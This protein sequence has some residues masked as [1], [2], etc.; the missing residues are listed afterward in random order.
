MDEVLQGKVACVD[1]DGMY[2]TIGY[3]IGNTPPFG[4]AHPLR[5][6]A[7]QALPAHETV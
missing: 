3:M 6:A 2:D 5:A 1:A 7:G 4:C